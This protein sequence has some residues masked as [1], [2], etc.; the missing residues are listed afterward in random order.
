MSHEIMHFLEVSVG[1]VPTLEGWSGRLGPRH[2][3]PLMWH[4]AHTNFQNCS[5]KNAKAP[6]N[7]KAA[8]G[9]SRT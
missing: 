9:A 5:Y 4:C 1:T 2:V 6:N 3:T 7:L 8:A